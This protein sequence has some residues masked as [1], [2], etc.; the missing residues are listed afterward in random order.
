MTRVFVRLP[1]TAQDWLPGVQVCDLGGGIVRVRLHADVVQ[2]PEAVNG[3][4]DVP[5]R[6]VYIC[7]SGD[8]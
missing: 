6:D 1:S 8:R 4:V 7:R 5:K 3:T 2:P